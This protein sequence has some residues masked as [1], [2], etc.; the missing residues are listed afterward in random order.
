MAHAFWVHLDE[1]CNTTAHDDQWYKKVENILITKHGLRPV[2]VSAGLNQYEGIGRAV[3][4][5]KRFMPFAFSTNKG[6]TIPGTV[7][8]HEIKDSDSLMLL[9]N[10][11]Q[12]YM[13]LIT[14]C[15]E[16]N[17]YLLDFSDERPVARH[18]RNGIGIFDVGRLAELKKCPLPQTFEPLLA[19]S[20]RGRF[21]PNALNATQTT[22]VNDDVAKSCGSSDRSESSDV[23]DM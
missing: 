3:A 5:L 15:R 17:I 4:S 1:C 8:S 22:I 23:I 6:R 14:Y 2:T 13:G 19:D 20:G 12:A 21:Q 9:S 10:A 18:C 7:E 11:A 16:G